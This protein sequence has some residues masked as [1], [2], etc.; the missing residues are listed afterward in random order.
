[1]LFRSKKPVDSKSGKFKPNYQITIISGCGLVGIILALLI[2]SGEK[3]PN[4]GS[5]FHEVGY[6]PADVVN[7]AIR[8]FTD[9]LHTAIGDYRSK[10]RTYQ[11][12]IDQ[13]PPADSIS[14]AMDSINSFS[15]HITQDSAGIVALNDDRVYFEDSTLTDTNALRIVA[16]WVHFGVNPNQVAHWNTVYEAVG[17]GWRDSVP[18]YARFPV[19]NRQFVYKGV[20]QFKIVSY[21]SNIQ[22]TAKYP[23]AAAWVFLMVLF[24]GFCFITIAASG[25]IMKQVIGIF[26]Q[27]DRPDWNGYWV[28]T[29][30]VAGCLML[31]LFI[32]F[33]TFGDEPPVKDLFFMRTLS[34]FLLYADILGCV[35]GAFCLA[36]FIHSVSMLGYFADKLKTQTTRVRQQRE[37][38]R[39]VG[40]PGGAAAVAAVVGTAAA[41]EA[42]V[43][44]AVPAP[45]EARAIECSDEEEAKHK[46]Y[47]DQFRRLLGFFHRYFILSSVLLS[48]VVLCTGALYNATNSLSFIKLLSVNW[49]YSPAGG[50]AVYLFGGLFTAILLLVYLPTKMQFGDVQLRLPPDENYRGEEDDDSKWYGILEQPFSW[51]KGGL[52]AASPFLLGL[53]Q[54]VL[55]LFMN[56]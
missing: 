56:H 52:I 51:L 18:Y 21:K 53:V 42:P 15:R 27:E 49:G 29:A 26:K 14:V 6:F 17:S 50:D 55:G 3:P 4:T 5:V 35:A 11:H 2:L 19:N 46:A 45:A 1:M 28:I 32:L 22:F 16:N 25:Y 31:F 20:A 38:V 34:R 41:G 36:G 39:R 13:K 44:A 37:E 54:G 48:M 40:G 12:V 9:S 30:I 33:H 24:W 47:A 23:V 43:V 8:H 10:K 7:R